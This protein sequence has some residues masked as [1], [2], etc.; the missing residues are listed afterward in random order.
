MKKLNF[1]KEGKNNI[2]YI[3]FNKKTGDVG[4]F[5]RNTFNC[6][7]VMTTRKDADFFSKQLN[8][9]DTYCGN[10]QKYE[11]QRILI[12]N[13]NQM[14]TKKKVAKKATKKVVKKVAKKK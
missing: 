4:G 9:S 14:A 2:G 8:E 6:L 12:I 7:A 5:D 11:I 10:P 3:V 13:K 1:K